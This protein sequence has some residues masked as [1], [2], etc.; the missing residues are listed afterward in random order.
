MLIS[1]VK[2]TVE[3]DQNVSRHLTDELYSTDWDLLVSLS[4]AKND[5]YDYNTLSYECFGHKIGN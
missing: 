2:D 3:V 5:I 1:Q 4:F